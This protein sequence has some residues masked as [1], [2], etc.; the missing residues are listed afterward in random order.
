MAAKDR[1]TSIDVLTNGDEFYEAELQ[2]IAQAQKHVCIEAYIFNKGE[3]AQRFVDALIER[4]LT[5]N[6]DVRIA[7]AS[8]REARALRPS[9]R[10]FSR[11]GNPISG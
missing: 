11:E 10:T 5:N 2:A 7:V 9:C 6:H 1:L 3:I 8:V 4:A